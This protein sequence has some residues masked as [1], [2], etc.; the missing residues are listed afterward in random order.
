MEI[1]MIRRHTYSVFAVISGAAHSVTHAAFSALP[2]GEADLRAGARSAGRTRAVLI[3]AALLV[4]R[5]RVR[6]LVVVNGLVLVPS[7]IENSRS[8]A[9]W[10]A[11]V[12]GSAAQRWGQVLD[13]VGVEN[14][15]QG[16]AHSQQR[17]AVESCRYQGDQDLGSSRCSQCPHFGRT[18]EIEKG[19]I[20]LCN[21]DPHEAGLV[22]LQSRGSGS[23]QQ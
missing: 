19:G 17:V 18:R 12:P 4:L 8:R 23:L 13:G 10:G 2:A 1:I 15:V 22:R 6:L 9:D 16:G 5:A 20:S 7:N 14:R 3:R 11:C 21:P